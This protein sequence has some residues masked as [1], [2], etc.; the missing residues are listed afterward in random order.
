MVFDIERK[1]SENDLGTMKNTPKISKLGRWR[2]RDHLSDFA[3]FYRFSCDGMLV[4]SDFF[5]VTL[6]KLLK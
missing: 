3:D 2:L 5:E 1:Q 4:K 6:V